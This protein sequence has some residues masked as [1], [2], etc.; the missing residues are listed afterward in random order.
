MEICFPYNNKRWKMKM[1]FTFTTIR[2]HSQSA[3]SLMDVSCVRTSEYK[4]PSNPP[5]INEENI[6]YHVTCKWYTWQEEDG[7]IKLLY[8]WFT[9]GPAAPCA[10]SSHRTLCGQG[11]IFFR[12]TCFFINNCQSLFFKLLAEPFMKNLNVQLFSA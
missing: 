8:I 11:W 1:S 9:A 10:W 4:K 5:C 2:P 12:K 6:Y 7:W 3:C